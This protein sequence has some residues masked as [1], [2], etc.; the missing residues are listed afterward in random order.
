MAK[1]SS[2]K[3]HTTVGKKKKSIIGKWDPDPNKC[4]YVV[5][6]RTLK[7]SYA[8]GPKGTQ[9]GAGLQLYAHKTTQPKPPNDSLYPAQFLL[10]LDQARRIGESLINIADA[11]EGRNT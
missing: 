5:Y 1:C 8:R 6:H 10:T 3:G 4:S 7:R 9:Q 11:A 2:K